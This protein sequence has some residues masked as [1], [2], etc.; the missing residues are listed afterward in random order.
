[1]E[2]DVDKSRY[3]MKCPGC[4]GLGLVEQSL[5]EFGIEGAHLICFVCNGHKT[6]L[7]ELGVIVM[8][9]TEA[10]LAGIEKIREK[11]SG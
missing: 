10:N 6:V 2:F 5:L 8:P 1:M 4:N 7:R 3:F 11:V 9:S